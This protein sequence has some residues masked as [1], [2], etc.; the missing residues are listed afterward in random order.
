MN[1]VLARPAGMALRAYV[2]Y[3]QKMEQ[4]VRPA[5]REHSRIVTALENLATSI[6][7]GTEVIIPDWPRPARMTYLHPFK[8][9]YERQPDCLFVIRLRHYAQRPIER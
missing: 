9:F 2:R 1:V 8:V 5:I 3:V 7:D 6:A 4:D